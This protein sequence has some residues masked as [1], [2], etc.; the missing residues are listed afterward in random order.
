MLLASQR[1]RDIY[2]SASSINSS[3]R[4]IG[5]FPIGGNK[6]GFVN[7]GGV[8]T[9][10]G[11]LGGANSHAAGIN[12]AGKIVGYADDG[13]GHTR[14][15]IY[16]NGVMTDL[17]TLGGPN[18]RA[19]AINN[20][21][22]IVGAADVA[23]APKAYSSAFLLRPGVLMQDLGRFAYSHQ[24]PGDTVNDIRSSVATPAGTRQNTVSQANGSLRFAA[25]ST[26]PGIQHMPATLLL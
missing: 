22:D 16:M 14:A 10:L 9:D 12:T 2:C 8:I 21:D 13:A 20:C 4:V 23:P 18:S 7:A 15:F 1:F 17:G 25:P 19:G 26:P 5:D 11:T 24:V 3:G 6:H